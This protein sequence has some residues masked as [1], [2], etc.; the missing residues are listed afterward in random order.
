[1]SH[2][3]ILSSAIS[4]I[5]GDGTPMI[6]C[7]LSIDDAIAW[8]KE[9]YPYSS[10]C[11]VQDWRWLDIEVSVA[12]HEALTARGVQPVILFANHIV[13]DSR[14]RWEAGSW[15]RSTALHHYDKEG[16]FQTMNTVYV[17]MG[18]GVRQTTT[19]AAL[20]SIT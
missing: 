4:I 16:A 20:Q 8:V 10:F 15:V 6:G 13:F 9:R 17:L 5:H 11:L 2:I 1:M 18:D 7:K 14:A 3:E 12:D 19:S